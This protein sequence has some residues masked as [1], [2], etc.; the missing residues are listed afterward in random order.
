[1]TWQSFC[2]KLLVT[3]DDIDVQKV[4]LDTAII[5]TVPIGAQCGNCKG[6]RLGVWLKEDVHREADNE[7]EEERRTQATLTVWRK[8]RMRRKSSQS[9][10]RVC[11][12]GNRASCTHAD[13]HTHTHTRTQEPPHTHTYTHTHTHKTSYVDNR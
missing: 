2:C 5:T 8:T 11:F 6:R 13:T 3:L 12:N 7:E 9:T 1:M 4:D 10:T